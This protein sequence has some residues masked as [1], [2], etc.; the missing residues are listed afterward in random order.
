M[1]NYSKTTNKLITILRELNFS[2]TLIVQ[3]LWD[4]IFFAY[5]AFAV[6]I[7]I[8]DGSENISISILCQNTDENEIQYEGEYA[9]HFS[10]AYDKGLFTKNNILPILEDAIC[11][12]ND[13]DYL[14]FGEIIEFDNPESVIYKYI[15]LISASSNTD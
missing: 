12:M 11:N 8:D 4:S 2:P 7:T 9:S 13:E 5:N 14:E 3:K 15:E 1:T 6:E 10:K